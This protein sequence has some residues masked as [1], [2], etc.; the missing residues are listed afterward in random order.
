MKQKTFRIYLERTEYGFVDIEGVETREQALDA[1]Y[2]GGFDEIQLDKV[3]NQ[4]M[5]WK[6]PTIN[7]VGEIKED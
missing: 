4:G 6:D 3:L 2:D 7:N 5:G 1:Y